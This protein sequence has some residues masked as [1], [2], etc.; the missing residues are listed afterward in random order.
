MKIAAF[1][2]EILSLHIANHNLF[3]PHLA[4]SLK[5][6]LTLLMV[7]SS[8]TI[9]HSASSGGIKK[10]QCRVLKYVFIC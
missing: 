1:L 8:E 4:A 6:S 7:D 5:G 3:C 2:P 9:S 10:F